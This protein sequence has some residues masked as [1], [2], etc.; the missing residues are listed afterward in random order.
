MNERGLAGARHAADDRQRVE[1]DPDRHVLEVVL[2]RAHEDEVA[3]ASAA[4]GREGDH[5]ASGDVARGQRARRLL[6][7]RLRAGED[8]L[9]APLARARSELDDVIRGGDELAVVL[10]DDDGVARPGE[11][12]TQLHEAHR[13][14][15]VEA[16]RRFVEHV[17]CADEL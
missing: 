6:E 15:R 8:D 7:L 10:D 1:R 13:V 17:E 12:A 14:A 9:A 5:L 2:A 4:E 11:L 16:D 3:P